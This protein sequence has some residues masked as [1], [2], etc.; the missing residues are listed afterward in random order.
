M[1]KKLGIR[2]NRA[3]RKNRSSSCHQTNTLNK[4]VDDFYE[5]HSP[6]LGKVARRFRGVVASETVKAAVHAS[7]W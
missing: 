6:G 7:I 2:R 1:K 3:N 5:I 4:G